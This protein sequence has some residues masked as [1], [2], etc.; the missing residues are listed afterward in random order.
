MLRTGNPAL[1]SSTFE[2]FDS[3]AAERSNT[4]TLNGTATKTG[5]LLILL[6]ASAGYSWIELRSARQDSGV[7]PHM[8]GG[9][10]VSL[11]AGVILWFKREWAAVLAPSTPLPR[12][13]CW[14]CFRPP[15]RRSFTGSSFKPSA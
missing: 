3:Y 12:A 5:M 13:W 4:M 14:E 1:N 15:S 2:T 8:V 6:T 10:I 7:I 11:L 9:L